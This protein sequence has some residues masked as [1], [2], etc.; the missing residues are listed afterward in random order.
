[1]SG[2]HAH[3]VL[4]IIEQ[5]GGQQ[6]KSAL[7][8]KVT[9]KFGDDAVFANCSGRQFTFDELIDFFQGKGRILIKGDLIVL[10][11]GDEGHCRH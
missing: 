3:E 6:E 2:I 1:M 7:R 10:N 5:F 9:E 11:L 4:E 8:Q